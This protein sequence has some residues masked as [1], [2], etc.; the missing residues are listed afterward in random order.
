MVKLKRRN[1][2][3]EDGLWGV[4]EYIDEMTDV[5]EQEERIADNERD[6]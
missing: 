3:A 2:E 4:W 1:E 5:K 6:N